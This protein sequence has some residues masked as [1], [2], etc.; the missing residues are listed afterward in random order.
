MPVLLVTYDQ[1]FS[2]KKNDSL[3][4]AIKQYKHVQLSENTFAIDTFE[5][6]RTIYNK[7]IP[8][9]NCKTNIY[10][11]TVTRPFTSQCLEE[12]KSWLGKRLPQF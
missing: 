6:T 4:A 7:L 5:N 11:L 2:T 9:L 1:S 12:V 3:V 10:I 8:H